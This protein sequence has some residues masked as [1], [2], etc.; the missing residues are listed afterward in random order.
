M[1]ASGTRGNDRESGYTAIELVIWTPILFFLMFGMVQFGLA[2]YAREV[3][4]SAAQEGALTARQEAA[5][6]AAKWQADANNT[7]SKW[8]R[9]LLG[10][11]ATQ[12]TPNTVGPAYTLN[13]RPSCQPVVGSTVSVQ[14]ISAIPWVTITVT[15]TSEGPEEKFYPAGEIEG[16]NATLP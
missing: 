1:R 16:C 5:N 2:V 10:G 4:V 3:T 15:S 13:G 9:D 11:A 14:V 8:A 7:A 6:P 12:I